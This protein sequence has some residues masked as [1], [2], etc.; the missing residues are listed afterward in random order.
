MF[1]HSLVPFSSQHMAA[2]NE[3]IATEGPIIAQKVSIKFTPDESS[4]QQLYK[5]IEQIESAQE[6]LESEI[7]EKETELNKLI[8]TTQLSTVSSNCHEPPSPEQYQLMPELDRIGL[9]ES[10]VATDTAVLAIERTQIRNSTLS[11][12]AFNYKVFVMSDSGR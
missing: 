11:P 4:N 9:A 8:L 7:A 10:Q 12:A 5:K 6:R 2:S 1:N 3:P